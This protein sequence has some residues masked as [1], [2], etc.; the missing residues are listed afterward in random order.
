MPKWKSRTDAYAPLHGEFAHTKATSAAT[1]STRPPTVSVRSAAATA[2][3]SGR[4]NRPR[5][6]RGSGFDATVVDPSE[7]GRRAHC[8][9]DADQTSRH[10]ART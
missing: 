2:L 1:S 3:R 9:T 7:T 6:V 8:P 5:N 10:T 4:D